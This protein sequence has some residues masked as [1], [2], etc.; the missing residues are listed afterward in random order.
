[1]NDTSRLSAIIGGS[2]AGGLTALIA[3]RMYFAGGVNTK[4]RD[5]KN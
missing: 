1:M 3:I 2:I 4:Y 5:L